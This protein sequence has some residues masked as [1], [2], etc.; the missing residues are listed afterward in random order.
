M[1][2]P[3]RLEKKASPLEEAMR[4]EQARGICDPCPWGLWISPMINQSHF[5]Q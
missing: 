5:W 2:I 1:G 4:S 3:N